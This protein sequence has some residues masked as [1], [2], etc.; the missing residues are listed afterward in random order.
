ML[1]GLHQC[2]HLLQAGRICVLLAQDAL[3]YYLNH[4]IRSFVA[5]VGLSLPL[6]NSGSKLYQCHPFHNNVFLT[7]VLYSISWHTHVPNIL[8]RCPVAA[9]LPVRL[10][11]VSIL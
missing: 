9:M 1:L 4:H 11:V 7:Q 3:G 10:N 2:Q 6:H 5:G 8:L